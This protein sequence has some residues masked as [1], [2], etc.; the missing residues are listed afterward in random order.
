MWSFR[1][2]YLLFSLVLFTSCAPSYYRDVST[3]SPDPSCIG[4]LTPPVSET[5]FYHASINVVGKHFSGLVFIKSLE[6][7]TRRVVFSSQTGL[8]LFDFEYGDNG[9]FHVRH[10][11][12]QLNN[13]LVIQTLRSDFSAMLGIPFSNKTVRAWKHGNELL[14]GVDDGAERIYLVTTL[15]CDS[16]KRTEIGS[17]R[18]RKVSI[19]RTGSGGSTREDITIRHYTFQMTIALKSIPRH[20]G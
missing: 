19:V 6:D 17:K 11:I 16:L 20:E 3:V 18:K 15:G 5:A 12:P 13:R 7:H 9:S 8:T 10:V 2:K 14:Y 4:K 1:M